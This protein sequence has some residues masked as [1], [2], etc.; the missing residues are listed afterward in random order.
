M[1]QV[2]SGPDHAILSFEFRIFDRWGTMLFRTN[3]LEDGWNGS[4]NGQQM[5][6][7][8]YVWYIKA[9]V[10]LCGLRE[11]DVIKKGDVTII[12]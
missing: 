9:K 3:Y 1:L 7:G 6:P 5:E 8:V 11:I 4:F 2:F 10:E 12:R